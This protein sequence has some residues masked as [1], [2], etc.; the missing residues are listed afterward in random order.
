MYSAVARFCLARR[1]ISTHM[2]ALLLVGLFLTVRPASGA[3][4]APQIVQQPAS[5]TVSSGTPVT[6]QVG[7]SGNAPL[8]YQWFRN[9][10][11]LP[12]ATSDAL[13]LTNG[14]VLNA[15]SYFVIV[16]NTA[17]SVT[18]SVARVRVDEELTFQVLALRT[19]GF[20]ALEANQITGDDRGGMA[21]S[22]NSVFL[23]GDTATGR[24]R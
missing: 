8:S 11:S 23:T 18:S 19:N 7:A 4:G 17:G 6:L 12:G 20:V 9:S 2:A 13:V 10:L 24:W 22:S 5:Q 15:G 14:S 21:V 16:T 1:R 3:A